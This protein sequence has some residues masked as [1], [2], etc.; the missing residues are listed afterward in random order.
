L[1]QVLDIS[2]PVVL[3]TNG[4]GDITDEVV[5]QLNA[6]APAAKSDDIKEEKKPGKK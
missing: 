3:Y 2:S 1:A 4:D 6:N 5:K